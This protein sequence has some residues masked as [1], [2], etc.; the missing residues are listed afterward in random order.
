[1]DGHAQGRN[2]YKSSNLRD[3]L[4]LRDRAECR[5]TRTLSGRFTLVWK[6]CG[7]PRENATLEVVDLV[8]PGNPLK[9]LDHSRAALTAPAHHDERPSYGEICDAGRQ[10]AQG[11]E[12][13]VRDPTGVML[14][15]LSD[16]DDRDVAASP[17]RVR[18]GGGPFIHR[19][20]PSPDD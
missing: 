18:V 3:L 2:G 19:F 9:V 12:R 13:Y 5:H 10:L 17:C 6:T 8:L 4:T 7:R 1:M 20:A 16:V 15:L 14:N 11:Y